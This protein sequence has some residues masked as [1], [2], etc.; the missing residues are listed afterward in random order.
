MASQKFLFANTITLKGKVVNI[1]LLFRYCIPQYI[2]Q[3]NI[4]ANMLALMVCF[5]LGRCS[6]NKEETCKKKVFWMEILA[7]RRQAEGTEQTF[8][9]ESTTTAKPAAYIQHYYGCSPYY[10]A[11]PGN[12]QW[13]Q[14]NPC[15]RGHCAVVSK[16]RASSK[17]PVQPSPTNSDFPCLTNTQFQCFADAGS[18]FTAGKTDQ[19]EFKAR[20]GCSSS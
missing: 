4:M 10:R 11:G 7:E 17:W 16:G 5:P 2:S 3:H 8:A 6:S 14:D 20:V 13:A 12:L 19:S 9:A 1:P 15:C 18:R